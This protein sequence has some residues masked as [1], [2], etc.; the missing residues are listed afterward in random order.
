[1]PPSLLP[2]LGNQLN[3]FSTTEPA[4]EQFYAEILY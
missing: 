4:T 3:N 1:M 2:Q